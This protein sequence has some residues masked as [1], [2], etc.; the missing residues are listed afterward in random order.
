MG[1]FALLA[2][3]S[4]LTLRDQKVQGVTLLLLAM[5]AFRTW[6]HHRKQQSEAQAERDEQLQKV[7]LGRPM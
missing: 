5:F 7:K 1:L 2:L 6:M 4:V 3:I